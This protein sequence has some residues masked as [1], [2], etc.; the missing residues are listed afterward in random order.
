MFH[1]NDCPKECPKELTIYNNNILKFAKM[2]NEMY[3][4]ITITYTDA[5]I[6]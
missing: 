1:S 6:S 4:S 2:E 5:P 3:K